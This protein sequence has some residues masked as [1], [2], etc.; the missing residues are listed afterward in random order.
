MV[1]AGDTSGNHWV[2]IPFSHAAD[3]FG[4]IA[5]MFEQE[6]AEMTRFGTKKS[7]VH[8]R[9]DAEQ[10]AHNH[11]PGRT[12][13]VGNP[14]T[15]LIHTIGGGFFNEPKYYDSTRSASDFCVELF[16]TG[17]ISSTIV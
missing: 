16:S 10:V 3:F 11:V 17:P 6:D 2:R 14:V 4:S 1:Q 12:Y 7:S 8:D 9:A 5:K 13:D 15:K